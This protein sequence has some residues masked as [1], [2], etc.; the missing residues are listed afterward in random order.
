LLL[1]TA[2]LVGQYF[3]WTFILRRQVQFMKFSTDDKNRKLAKT[4]QKIIV[5]FSL[6]DDPPDPLMNR[7][8][9]GDPSKARLGS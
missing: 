4:F 3:S 6:D 2:F 5:A 1:Y 7:S 9:C 8:R